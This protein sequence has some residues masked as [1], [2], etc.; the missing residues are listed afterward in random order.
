MSNYIELAFAIKD[1]TTHIEIETRNLANMIAARKELIARIPEE[2]RPHVAMVLLSDGIQLDDSVEMFAD[3]EPTLV[4]KKVLME[5]EAA[6]KV[7]AEKVVLDPIVPV[8]E[9]IVF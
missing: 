7:E 8:T 1:A 6:A 2:A 4:A 5:A 9:P 3:I